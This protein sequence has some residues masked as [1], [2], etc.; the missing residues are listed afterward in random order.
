MASG[1]EIR[2]LPSADATYEGGIE[3]SPDGKLFAARAT[4]FGS[5]MTGSVTLLDVA[6]WQQVRVL[7][8]TY[9]DEPGTSRRELRVTPMTFSGDS[10]WLAMSFG[11]GVAVVDAASGSRA[12]V[13]RTT[14]HQTALSTTRRNVAAEE[15]WRSSGADPNQVRDAMAGAMGAPGNIER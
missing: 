10:R 11:E 6:T 4:I 9:A 8:G 14:E 3:F 15:M 12:R 13:L 2:R 1:R 5:G 7:P